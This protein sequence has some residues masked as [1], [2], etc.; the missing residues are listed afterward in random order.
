MINKYKQVKIN[1]TPEQ[2]ENVAIKAND[3][4]LKLSTYLKTIMNLKNDLDNKKIPAE[5]KRI[6]FLFNNLTNN[7]NQVAKKVNYE[8]EI[9]Q[10]AL[11][12]LFEIET[13]SKSILDEI[14]KICEGA[15]NVNNI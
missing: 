1:L 8:N 5:L 7:L 14:K 9:N 3:N 12:T 15:K 6:I 10:D 2:Y 4:S 13:N 11:Y